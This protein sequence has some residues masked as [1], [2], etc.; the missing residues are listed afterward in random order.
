MVSDSYQPHVQLT[1]GAPSLLTRHRTLSSGSELQ[2]QAQPPPDLQRCAN[3]GEAA[4]QS[5]MAPSASWLWGRWESDSQYRPS[6]EKSV[7]KLFIFLFF[8]RLQKFLPSIH[9]LAAQFIKIEQK[10][11]IFYKNTKEKVEEAAA[12]VV[13]YCSC[14]R[15]SICTN[16][17]N[18]SI[19]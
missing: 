17:N 4:R 7:Y 14:V 2:Y 10:I 9:L 5:T 6:I 3:E 16:K 8:P 13:Q 12:S 19:S 18:E 11:I 15:F 1:K